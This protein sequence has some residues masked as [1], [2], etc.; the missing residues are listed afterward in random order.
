MINKTTTWKQ[1]REEKQQDWYF[2]GQT[3]E[4]SLKR[5]DLDMSTETKI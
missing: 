4:I 2:K 3:D 5:K 1:K